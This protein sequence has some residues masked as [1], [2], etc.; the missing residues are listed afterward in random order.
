[1]AKGQMK[2]N[3]E[4]RKPKKDKVAAAP[5]ATLGSQ[6]KLAANTNSGKGK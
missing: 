6:V 3:K 1:M 5:V 4:T 2:S